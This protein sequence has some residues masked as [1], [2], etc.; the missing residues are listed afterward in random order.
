MAALNWIAT[1]IFQQDLFAAWTNLYLI[2][3]MES[4]LLQCLN[5]GRKIG[6]SSRSLPSQDA[7]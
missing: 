2:A 1:G 5:S 6:A 4:R 3:K 7:V